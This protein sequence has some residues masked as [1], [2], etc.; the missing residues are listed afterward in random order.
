VVPNA[1]HEDVAGDRVI[2]DF[3]QNNP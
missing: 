3:H 1:A 2:L